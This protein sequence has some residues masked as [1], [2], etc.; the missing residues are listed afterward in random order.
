VCR[1][2]AEMPSTT[3]PRSTLPATTSGTNVHAYA[4]YDWGLLVTIALMWGS[5]F[6]FIAIGLEA[7]A[8]G[9]ITLARVALGT[10]VLGLF[11]RAWA[12]VDRSDLPRIALLGAVWVAIPFSLFPI[13]QQWIS[14]S[15]AG[16]INGAMPIF[17][18][19][20]ATILLRQLP[21]WR[22]TV[23]IGIG[24]S[25][26]VLVFVPELQ[27]STANAFGA[28]LALLAVFFYGLA[29]NLAV[30]LQQRYGALPVIFRVQ[31]VSLVL[32][33]P[34]GLLGLSESTWSVESALAMIPL[35]IFG[36]GF[37]L[38]LMATLAGRV[39]GPRASIAIYFLPLVAIV[40]GVA[41]LD[42][43]VAPVALA[44]VGLILAGAWIASRGEA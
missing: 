38:V 31:A 24:F 18:V 13:S 22:Q 36:T 23:G 4:L 20:W 37:A 32:V 10:A 19:A 1:Y 35:G 8:P 12:P 15:V 21:G 16:M 7:F 14:S 25:G 5:S 42:E 3:R 39:G 27:G 26:I 2:D 28:F 33:A 43:T 9:V 41:L 30:P 44:G 29:A 11:A 34:L 40:L 6:L 17:A